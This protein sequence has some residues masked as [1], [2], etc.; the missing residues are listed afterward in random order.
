MGVVVG[1]GNDRMTAETVGKLYEAGVSLQ[2]LAERFGTGRE[3]IR[4]LLLAHQKASRSREDKR[5][6]HDN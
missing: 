3:K 1:K 5:R 4:R 2:N 6:A